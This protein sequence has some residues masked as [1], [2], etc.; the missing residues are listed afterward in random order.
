MAA[1]MGQRNTEDSKRK[2]LFVKG[3]QRRRA[4]RGE[5]NGGRCPYG[6]ART[7]DV[8][9][10][11]LE[12]EAAM[13]RRVFAEF[14]GGRSITAIARGLQEDQVPT[15]GGGVWRTSTVIGILDNP[16]CI[17]LIPYNGE[18]LPGNHEPIIDEETWSKART[19]RS[20][21]VSRRGRHPKGQHLFR[22]GHMRC[23]ICNEAIVPRTS[24]ARQ[25]YE[26][27]GRSKLGKGHCSMPYIKRKTIDGAVYGYFENTGLDVQAT[28]EQLAKA[29]ASKL[30]EVDALA[31]QAERE[32]TRLRGESERVDRDYRAGDLSAK[33][34]EPMA[35]EIERDLAGAEAEAERLQAQRESF[36]SEELGDAESEVLTL[37]ATIRKAVA[38][39]ISEAEDLD[40]VRASMR[41]LFERLVLNP[42]LPAGNRKPVIRGGNLDD[43]NL[44]YPADPQ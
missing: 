23:G 28:I 10:E 31:V 25:W 33:R 1:M 26:C 3:G 22:G 38:G 40:A 16:T 2:T 43:G 27:N 12:A 37:L 44:P 35:A 39:E 24:G 11:P 29:R 5:H 17:G 14:A 34:Y 4:E 13:V 41:R 18:T 9:L 19:L 42:R 20:K 15:R 8:R 21:T 30:E 32:V 6:Y 7:P 36:A